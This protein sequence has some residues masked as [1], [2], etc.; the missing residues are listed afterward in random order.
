M[1]DAMSHNLDGTYNV[2][3]MFQKWVQRTIQ[4]ME[5]S[6][7]ELIFT[8]HLNCIRVYDFWISI[9]KRVRAIDWLCSIVDIAVYNIYY[10]V[11]S[12]GRS[13]FYVKNEPIEQKWISFTNY[14][15]DD[16]LTMETYYDIRLLSSYPNRD[17]FIDN[18]VQVEDIPTLFN[19]AYNQALTY[20]TEVSKET[21]ITMAYKNMRFIYL[22]DDTRQDVVVSMEPSDIDFIL[23]EYTHPYMESTMTIHLPNSIYMVGNEILSTAFVL[24]YLEYTSILDTW[25][26]DE[27]YKIRIIDHNA[28]QIVLSANQYIVLGKD[29]YQIITKNSPIVPTIDDFMCEPDE[30]GE[31]PE[32]FNSEST[33][34]N[35]DDLP[36]LESVSEE[37]GDLPELESG[38]AHPPMNSEPSY[39]WV[40]KIDSE[41]VKEKIE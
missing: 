13:I 1:P 38:D 29:G 9:R 18:D 3:I 28:D 39:D 19:N 24:R 21:L 41:N 37:D 27:K 32:D 30:D 15:V 16:P 35:G 31:Y 6:F 22:Y 36:E 11:W 8:F 10:L 20:K 25:Y 12:V 17:K 5:S 14:Y 33:S 34:E 40:F 7:L 4:T 2:D 23:V 26:F